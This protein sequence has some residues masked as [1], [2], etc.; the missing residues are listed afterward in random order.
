[1]PYAVEYAVRPGQ[2]AVM[3]APHPDEA[4]AA[5]FVA[6]QRLLQRALPLLTDFDFRVAETPGG[7]STAVATDPPPADAPPVPPTTRRR[8]RA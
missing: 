2:W 4:A 1:M 7:E 3:G 5:A 8:S 6:G